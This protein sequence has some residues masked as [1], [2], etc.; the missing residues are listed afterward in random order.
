PGHRPFTAAT[1]VQIPYGTPKFSTVTFLQPSTAR[2]DLPDRSLSAAVFMS[3]IVSKQTAM[4]EIR[5]PI[6]QPVRNE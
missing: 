6:F 1:R 2:Q 3:L 4:A 5:L